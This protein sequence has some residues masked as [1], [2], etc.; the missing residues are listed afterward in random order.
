MLTELDS[1]AGQHEVI[2]DNFKRE[3][4][5]YHFPKSNFPQIILLFFSPQS[6]KSA[7]R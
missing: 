6:L 1:L 5:V 2:G 3:I 4:Y 7:K